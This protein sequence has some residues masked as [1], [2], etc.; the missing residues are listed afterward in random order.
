M[1]PGDGRAPGIPNGPLVRVLR[2]E[3]FTF[4]KNDMV[5]DGCYEDLAC[6]HRDFPA[7]WGTS[8]AKRRCWRCLHGWAIGR[9]R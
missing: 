4:E 6:G 5:W 7:P 9:L 2:R 8:R 3:V 1:K